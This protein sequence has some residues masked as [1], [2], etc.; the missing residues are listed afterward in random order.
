[1]DVL[2]L[3]PEETLPKG[4]RGPLDDY[5]VLHGGSLSPR[6]LA[7]YIDSGISTTW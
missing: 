5:M 2:K 6:S 7:N 3:K 1:M 4:W